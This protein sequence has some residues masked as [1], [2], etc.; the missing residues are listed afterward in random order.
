[1]QY[2]ILAGGKA[3]RFNGLPKE[4]LPANKEDTFLDLHIKRCIENWSP[5]YDP[6][7]RIVSNKDKISIHQSICKKYPQGYINFLLQEEGE[8]YHAI[9][10]GNNLQEDGN[11]FFLADSYFESKD[12]YN[13]HSYC[14]Y[15][16]IFGTFYTTETE[17]FSLVDKE[18]KR[19]LTK[20]KIITEGES[21][22]FLYWRSK[23]GDIVDKTVA[24]C[25]NTY[26]LVLEEM[27]N[28]CDFTTIKIDK[29][30]D[31]GNFDYYKDFLNNVK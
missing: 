29:Y 7:I 25:Y 8:L 26:D 3:T 22:G 31:I 2:V 30:Y 5:R 27:M 18:K 4:C 10:M 11:M 17:R 19:I 21:W 24:N 28:N 14:E 9:K 16:L 1:M 23:C 6:P 12:Y 13:I 15:D 20:Q